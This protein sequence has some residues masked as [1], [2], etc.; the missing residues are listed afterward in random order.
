MNDDLDP[1]RMLASAALDTEVD[2]D[3]RARVDASPE[4][5]E[6]VELYRSIGHQI[7]QVE[8]P[9][10]SRESA[11]FAALAVFDERPAEVA[12]AT[13]SVASL[14]ERRRVQQAW[15]GRL[16]RVTG[17]LAAAAVVAVVGVAALKSGSG[18]SK[19]SSSTIAV[20][21]QTA[22]SAA[23]SAPN[24]E[25]AA[26]GAPDAA[27]TAAAATTTAGATDT[28]ASGEAT[29]AINQTAPIDPWAAAP[30]FTSPE[31]LR[32]YAASVSAPSSTAPAQSS[33]ARP[34]DT[35]AGT[36]SAASAASPSPPTTLA[37]CA[38]ITNASLVPAY[39][40]GQ[41]VYLLRDDAAA[42]LR[43]LEPTTCAVI[44]TVP[45]G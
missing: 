39:Y 9:S 42:L 21:D 44:L 18:D 4:L 37:A 29:S 38:T 19:K 10:S 45:L 5:R 22:A 7:R 25:S 14:D 33:D 1:S 17:G 13:A 12:G 2:A 32:S 16:G 23:K 15:L 20:F 3:E 41:R 28:T 30:S 27:P 35:T 36:T 8:V 40:G 24:V 6:E 26:G 43:V 11:V 34:I 31:E